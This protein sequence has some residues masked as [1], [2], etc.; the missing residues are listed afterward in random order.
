M[1]G[2][3]K[4][5]AIAA[6]A[7]RP[8]TRAAST[9]MCAASNAQHRVARRGVAQFDA[10][11][12]AELA[13]DAVSNCA[14][15]SERGVVQ[16][17]QGAEGVGCKPGNAEGHGRCSIGE[18][19][20]VAAARRGF[21]PIPDMTVPGRAG[22]PAPRETPPPAVRASGKAISSA[23]VPGARRCWRWSGRSRRPSW[24][25]VPG[26]GSRCCPSPRRPST[27]GWRRG[28]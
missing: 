22:T 9:I 15:Q 26:P 25:C 20:I 2:L 11:G 7:S 6:S 27:A 4:S 16:A 1:A 21:S 8:S 13:V 17:E 14:M 3:V 28:R 5:R 10:V 12:K 18:A 23:A 24:A 19:R